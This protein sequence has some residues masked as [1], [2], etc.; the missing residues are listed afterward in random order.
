MLEIVIA[1]G[2]GGV[3]KSTITST[4][5]VY[6]A[7]KGYDIIMIDADADAPNLHLIFDVNKWEEETTI[8]DAWVAE[9]DY[10][11]CTNCGVCAE[12]CPYKAVKLVNGKYTI[13]PVIC[14]GCLT[15][16]IACP[17]KAIKRRKVEMGKIWQA[18]TNY[19]FKLFSSELSVGRPNSGKLVTEIK[20]K[21]KEH[22]GKD[23]IV[24]VDAAAGI[25]CQV[26]SSF[27]GAH[28]TILVVE[29]TPAS[30]SDL[31]RVHM[32][33]KQFMLPAGLVINKFDINEEFAQMI[34]EYAEKE[35][36]D[37][38]G[39]I[40]FDENVPLS[41]AMMK[42]LVEAYPNSK[43]SSALLEI[44]KKIEE[45][46]IMNSKEWRIKFRPRKITPYRPLMVHTET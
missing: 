18:T 4:L 6:L 8:Y 30:F 24:L 25:G 26:I 27:A 2:K 34:I 37:F 46:L 19:G 9:I 42:P 7:N 45:R 11:K 43:A 33:S 44:S 36:I 10:S 1:S 41:M 32:V 3:G 5:G 13:N 29:P 21:A 12:V 35:N 20:N 17:E 22:A 39:T 38:L 28:E 16:T 31:K 23:T 40:P 15:C 14:E